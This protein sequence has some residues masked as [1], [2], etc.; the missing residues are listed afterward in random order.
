MAFWNS[1]ISIQ[2]VGL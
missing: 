1:N 2:F